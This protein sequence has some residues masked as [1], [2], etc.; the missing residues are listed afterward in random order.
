MGQILVGGNNM[1]PAR[2]IMFFHWLDG[3]GFYG[4][5]GTFCNEF[6]DNQPKT[7]ENKEYIA[8]FR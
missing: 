2:L 7:I 1:S 8:Q 4:L 5:D 3:R 6:Q